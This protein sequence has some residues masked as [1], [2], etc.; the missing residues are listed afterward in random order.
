M[1]FIQK[2]KKINDMKN[3]SG[4]FCLHM[5]SKNL[6][7]FNKNFQTKRKR[8]KSFI[9]FIQI[10]WEAWQTL[11]DVIN[12]NENKINFSWYMRTISSYFCFV[13]ICFLNR[14]GNSNC[15]STIKLVE[16]YGCSAAINFTC[17]FIKC[18]LDLR[19]F[20]MSL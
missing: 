20:F 9:I 17:S 7:R 1:P 11:C 12:F 3:I 15:N 13:Y 5:L 14:H 4:Y 19:L 6:S 16:E 10:C 18:N 2:K 8:I